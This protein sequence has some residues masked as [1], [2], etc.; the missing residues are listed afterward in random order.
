MAQY[1][2]MDERLIY[3]IILG[4]AFILA[5]Q[6]ITWPIQINPWTQDAYDTVESLPDGSVAVI[7]AQITN[8]VNGATSEPQRIVLKHF[9]QKGFKV[10]VVA[11]LEE[12]AIFT[13]HLLRYIYGDPVYENPLYGEEIVYLGFLPG[14]SSIYELHKQ[15][16]WAFYPV[17]AYGNTLADMPITQEIKNVPDDVDIIYGINA[18]GLDGAFAVPFGINWIQCAGSGTYPME[19]VLGV[20]K[21]YVIGQKGAAEYELLSGIKSAGMGFVSI[22]VIYGIFV[23]IVIIAIN[24]RYA[25]RRSQEA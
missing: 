22:M 16:L 17:D 7:Y 12:S 13:E 10:I 15:D 1:N 6:P 19:W 9:I 24:I 11:Q 4:M 14:L 2:F 23:T 8:Y 5:F 18:R 20:S 25:M 21:G 3:V